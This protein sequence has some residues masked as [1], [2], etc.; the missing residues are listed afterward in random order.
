M[1]DVFVHPTALVETTDIGAGTRIWAM[2]HVMKHAVIGRN[3][4]IGDHSFVESGAIVGNDVTVKNGN[5]LLDGLT[6]EDGVFVGPRVFF[7]NDLY[8][9]SA[10][11]P[12]VNM[13]SAR[14]EWLVTTCVQHG[15]SLGAGSIILG[16][17]T[18]GAFAMVGAGAVVTR[19][20]PRHALVI[21]NPARFHGW[22]CRCGRPLTF[23]EDIAECGCGLCFTHVPADQQGT[24]IGGIQELVITERDG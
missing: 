24:E 13:R 9:R 22:V 16:G 6:L 15:A 20:V 8:P 4:N 10:R 21:G 14:E 1:N 17:V 7:T 11:S 19:D 23:E 18:I 12:L 3:C 5:M 2:V